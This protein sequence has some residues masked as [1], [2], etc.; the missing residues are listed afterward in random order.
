MK[1]EGTHGVDFGILRGL[2]RNS[3]GDW[4]QPL[5]AYH[6]FKWYHFTAFR[7]GDYSG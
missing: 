6:L 3:F 4:P 7:L 2:C 1:K 5:I